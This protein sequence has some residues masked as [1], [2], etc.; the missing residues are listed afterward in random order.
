MAVPEW[1]P[2]TVP[3]MASTVAVAGLLLLHV[4]PLMLFVKVV[5]CPAQTEVEPPIADGEANTVDTVLIIQP[6][7]RV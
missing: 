6:P 7:P 3:E 1:I 5:N 4:P 2:V